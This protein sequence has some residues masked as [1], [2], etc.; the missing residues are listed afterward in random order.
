MSLSGDQFLRLLHIMAGDHG[1]DGAFDAFA[2]PIL[3]RTKLNATLDFIAAPGPHPAR[4]AAVIQWAEDNGRLPELLMG[5]VELAPDRRELR[6]AADAVMRSIAAADPNPGGPAQKCPY[7]T[8]VVGTSPFVDRDS[9]RGVLRA[10]ANPNGARILSLSGPPC[11]GKTHTLLLLKAG[12]ARYGYDVAFVDVADLGREGAAP[13]NVIQVALNAMKIKE[14]LTMP[15]DP[16]TARTTLTLAMRAQALVSSVYPSARWWLVFDGLDSVG[17]TQ[18]L[19]GA[20]LSLARYLVVN[21]DNVRVALL[22]YQGTIAP[23]ADSYAQQETLSA[24]PPAQLAQCREQL[25]TYFATTLRARDPSIGDD[26]VS[27]VVDTVLQKVAG[28]GADT[29]CA[30]KALTREAVRRML[31]AP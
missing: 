21:L 4:T 16:Q 8:V 20:V 24:F 15:G 31:E 25:V 19:V 17:V 28:S 14:S 10:M 13:E 2:L 23:P 30:L 22:G 29:F 7:D 11:S 26:V 3:V 27:T 6:E 5:A 1:V 12:A 18:S 9:L